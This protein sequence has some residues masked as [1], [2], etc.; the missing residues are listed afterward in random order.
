MS[1]RQIGP[2][3]DPGTQLSMEALNLFLQSEHIALRVVI[4]PAGASSKM[5][6]GLVSSIHSFSQM[7]H[8]SIENLLSMLGLRASTLAQPKDQALR[9]YLSRRPCRAMQLER[10]SNIARYVAHRQSKLAPRS[11]D[12]VN[13]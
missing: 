6:S 12:H 13:G 8:L 5:D 2:Y 3:S 7:M 1:V 4:P 11:L 9:G 10:P